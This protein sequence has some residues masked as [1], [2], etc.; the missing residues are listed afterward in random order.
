LL[1]RRSNDSK[2]VIQTAVYNT[3]GQLYEPSC[4]LQSCVK[5]I[6]VGIGISIDAVDSVLTSLLGL[7]EFSI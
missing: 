4:S 2:A 1:T 3:L 6:G 7:S 5:G